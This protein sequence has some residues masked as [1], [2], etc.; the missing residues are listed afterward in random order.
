MSQD[1]ADQ[2][3]ASQLQTFANLWAFAINITSPLGVEFPMFN[4]TG[5]HHCHV[6]CIVLL[7]S[8]KF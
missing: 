8:I 4:P 3:G 6:T 5:L 2:Q 1:L 7:P